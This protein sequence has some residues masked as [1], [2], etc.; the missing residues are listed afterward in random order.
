M[1]AAANYQTQ[2]GFKR[3]EFAII[4]QLWRSGVPESKRRQGWF[5]LEAQ[6]ESV[7]LPVLA[8]RGARAPWLAASSSSS[9]PAAQHLLAFL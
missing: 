1:A 7:P 5:L 2:S 8:P 4:F 9:K 6:K 3:H